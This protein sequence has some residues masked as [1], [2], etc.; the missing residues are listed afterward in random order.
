MTQH[1]K[2]LEE[3]GYVQRSRNPKNKREIRCN[4]SCK[5]SN[6]YRIHRVPM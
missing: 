1:F 5:K 6:F 2:L 4:E 3:R